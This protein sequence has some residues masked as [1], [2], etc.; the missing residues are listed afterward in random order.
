MRRAIIYLA[1]AKRRLRKASEEEEMEIT[2]RIMLL[3]FCA[4]LQTIIER[5][6]NNVVN[7][8]QGKYK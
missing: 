8:S 5:A 1:E 3:D 2:D 7:K 6:E 4:R